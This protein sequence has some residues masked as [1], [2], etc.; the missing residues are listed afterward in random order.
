MEGENLERRKL[1]LIAVAPCYNFTPPNESVA[2]KVTVVIA[3][4]VIKEEGNIT[5]IGYACS[6]GPYCEFPYC[7]YS[8]V[9][10]ENLG[11]G[12]NRYDI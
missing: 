8:K 2:Q 5:T 10:K 7:R 9:G 3:P 4:I 12:A 11:K 6:C 1:N